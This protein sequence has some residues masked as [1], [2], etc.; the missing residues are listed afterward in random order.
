MISFFKTDGVPISGLWL[1]ATVG[2]VEGT[3]I[4]LGNPVM[5]DTHLYILT[6]FRAGGPTGNGFKKSGA[7][8]N[9]LLRL[10]AINVAAALERKFTI[11]WTHD[12]IIDGHI[13]YM[14]TGETYCDILSD[15]RHP[16]Q[17]FSSPGRVKEQSGFPLSVLTMA[18]GR[19]LVA[20]RFVSITGTNRSFNMSVKDLGE[21]Y[22]VISS[23]YSTN[24]VTSIS[25]S[26]TDKE[27]SDTPTSKKGQFQSVQIEGSKF[28]LTSSPPHENKTVLEVLTELAGMPVSGSSITLPCLLTTPATLL[29]ATSGD[30]SKSFK[31]TLLVF[32]SSDSV[33]CDTAVP[34]HESSACSSDNNQPHLVG[35]W[36]EMEGGGVPSVVWS[37]P[38]PHSQPVLGQISTLPLSP[39]PLLFL[40]TP[41]GVYAYTL[42]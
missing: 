5:N 38:L 29:Q 19:L 3:F 10:Y 26:N 21:T 11:L 13:P 1:N 25:W 37:V 34:G 42:T 30:S 6:A 23:G 15:T 9:M 4:P 17:R 7:D 12:V 20:V 35:V 24:L 31:P 16:K 32:G 28:W 39:N 22:S 27:Y 2:H 36:V 41:L 33:S 14:Y 8:N 18:A 40:T